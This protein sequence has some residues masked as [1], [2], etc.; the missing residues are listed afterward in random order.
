MNENQK[1]ES[2]AK[3]SK[4]LYCILIAVAVVVALIGVAIALLSDHSKPAN[5][6]SGNS[7]NGTVETSVTPEPTEAPFDGVIYNLKYTYELDGKTETWTAA[8][9]KPK[10]RLTWTVTDVPVLK[11]QGIRITFM[12][13]TCSNLPGCTFTWEYDEHEYGQVGPY[14]VMQ[15]GKEVLKGNT[16]PG[17]F[18]FTDLNGDGL[19][20]LLMLD[21]HVAEAYDFKNKT[22]GEMRFAREETYVW[23]ELTDEDFVIYTSKDENRKG[24]DR[25]RFVLSGDKLEY[26]LIVNPSSVDSI[27]VIKDDGNPVVCWFDY[28]KGD[29]EARQVVRIEE[30]DATFYNE[31]TDTWEDCPTVYV[32]DRGDFYLYYPNPDDYWLRHSSEGAI[33]TIFSSWDKGV[34][35]F[36]NAYVADLD[37]DASSFRQICLTFRYPAGSP[38]SDG[39]CLLVEGRYRD[40]ISDPGYDLRFAEENGKLVVKRTP[41]GG[42]QEETLTLQLNEYDRWVLPDRE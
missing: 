10:E 17:V 32:V 28:M 41:V 6:K 30:Y 36:L 34:E 21:S 38:I 5:S 35:K 29:A 33:D 19:Q 11:R 2:T 31:E 25:G 9:K 13:V 26:Q 22:T 15:D 20:E 7:T 12:E 39:T 23:C 40:R 1:E 18:H 8:V 4:K 16:S 37:G 42:G 3:G 14:K 27:R 24:Q